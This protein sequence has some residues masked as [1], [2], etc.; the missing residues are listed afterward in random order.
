MTCS[1]ISPRDDGDGIDEM[2]ENTMELGAVNLTGW[3]VYGL[4]LLS[5]VFGSLHSSS[6]ARPRAALTFGTLVWLGACL[7]FAT[8]GQR[9]D[10]GDLLL[11]GTATIIGVGIFLVASTL[12]ATPPHIVSESR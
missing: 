6:C 10:G 12:N 3:L 11:Y 1:C 2:I 5:C 4:A 9:V 7:P 8:I